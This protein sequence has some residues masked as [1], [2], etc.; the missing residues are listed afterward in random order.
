LPRRID[1][2]PTDIPSLLPIVVLADLV[3][4]HPRIRLMGTETIDAY[5]RETRGAMAADLQFGAFTPAWRE[6]LVKVVE[7]A[8]PV[9]AAG[10]FVRRDQTLYA[11]TVLTPL[12]DESGIVSHIFGALVITFQPRQR[13]VEPAPARSFVRILSDQADDAAPA[14]PGPVC[15]G[16][17][18]A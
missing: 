11:Q 18:P 6:A 16:A 12:A 3:D 10:S 9:C 5:G 8:A 4:S 17:Q 7:T 15:A 14:A 1:I 13:L 2:Q